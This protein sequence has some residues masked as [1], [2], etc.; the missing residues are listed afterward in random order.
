MRTA[1]RR[2][3]VSTVAVVLV[4]CGSLETRVNPVKIAAGGAST[5]TAKFTGGGES[6]AGQT[7]QFLVI[8]G[9]ECGQLDVAEA[10]MDAAGRAT[11]RYTGAAGVADCAAVIQA[12]FGGESSTT[13]VTVGA[14]T[15]AVRLDG[16]TAIA[17][18]V[19]A[20][21]AIDRIVRGAL[22]LLSF[23][24]RWDLAVQD[25]DDPASTH[26]GRKNFRLAY[27]VLAGA[28]GL[29]ALGWYGGVRILS[30]LGFQSVDP[31]LDTV[32]TGLLLVGGAE[33]TGALLQGLGGGG[34]AAASSTPSQPIEITGTLVLNDS[35]RRAEAD[36]SSRHIAG[37]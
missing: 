5:V 1:Y 11:A 34:L 27:F 12:A 9:E 19:I 7:V 22:F 36:V 37:V 29:V 30:A 15:A 6:L 20:S 4:G 26:G 18:V 3:G 13:D 25:P 10:V 32:V 21:F 2:F 16:V 17:A 35:G 8:D 31:V 23:W 33:R 14:A 28:L 24:R